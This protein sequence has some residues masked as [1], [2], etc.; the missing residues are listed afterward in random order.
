MVGSY[1][2]LLSTEIAE[3]DRPWGSST[4]RPQGQTCGTRVGDGRRAA[5]VRRGVMRISGVEEFGRRCIGVEWGEEGVQVFV[6][7]VLSFVR[8]VARASRFDAY[9]YSG[10]R[11]AWEV[12]VRWVV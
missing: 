5:V 6:C 11:R 1:C 9:R 2:I 12:G 4:E 3:T 10:H 7:V 8:L